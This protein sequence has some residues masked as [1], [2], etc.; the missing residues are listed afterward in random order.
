MLRY[1]LRR[2]FQGEVVDAVA[3]AGIGERVPGVAV[4][5]DA[6]AG[7]E[8]VR[9]PAHGQPQPSLFDRDVFPRASRM[10]RELP[11]VHAGRNRGAHELKRDAGL[12]RR[13]VSPL[14]PAG[15]ARDV[16]SRSAQNG[17]WPGSLLPQQARDIASQPHGNAV[18][19]QHTRG[20]LAALD[21]RKHAPADAAFLCGFVEREPSCTAQQPDAR[22]QPGEI[23]AQLAIT[24]SFNQC[25][26]LDSG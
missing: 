2:Y 19:H 6:I 21:S 25:N 12:H 16:L 14:P 10:R 3:G 9:A 13:Q 4:I 8:E 7:L 26:I 20:F 18:H 1:V 24:T 11:R 17:H 23:E 5:G 15:I 22:P